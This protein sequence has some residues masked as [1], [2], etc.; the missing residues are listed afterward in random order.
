M[1]NKFHTN[2][3]VSSAPHIVTESDTTRLM[4]TVILALVPAWAASVYIFGFR[5]LLLSVVCVA[6]SVLF[7][8]LYNM[9]MHKKQTVSDLSAALT[10]L[11]IAFNVPS[12]FPLWQAII[13]CFFAIIVVK[14]LFGGIGRNF[15]NPAITARIFLFISFAANMST[16]PLPRMQVTADA[17]TGATP[18]AIYA[19]GSMDQL[20]TLGT[21]FLGFHGGSTGEVCALALIIGG[22]FLIIRKVISPII[23]CAFIGTVFVFGFI[24]TGSLQMA[25]FHVLAG[26]VLLGAFFMATDYVTSPKLPLGQLIFGIGCGIITMSI[27]LFGSYPEGVSFSILLMNI[28]TPLLNNLSYKFYL[29]EGG[30]KNGK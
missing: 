18:L 21:L 9:F 29:K 3:I 30:A 12:S 20:P 5:A 22:V 14:Q 17:V 24:A 2:L 16:W 15:S 26:G 19:E 25:L 1:A 10:G 28:C 8:Y 13:G 7:E 23:P 27:R 4:G 11:L 6:A